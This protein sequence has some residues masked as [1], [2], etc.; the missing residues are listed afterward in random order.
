MKILLIT[1][2]YPP[3]WEAQSIRWYY[4]SKELAKLGF[5]V[6][7]LTIKLPIDRMLD[8]P[9]GINFI[10]ILPGPVENLLLKHK[11]KLNLESEHRANLHKSI[12]YSIGKKVY[13]FFRNL[14]SKLL[15]G[16]VRNEWFPFALNLLKKMDLTKYDILITSHEPM[17]DSLI[18][19]Y[20]KLYLNKNLFWVADIAD[21]LT[22]P[23]YPNI[24]KHILKKLEK[25]I[26]KHANLILVTNENLKHVYLSDYNIEKEK[27]LTLPQ[28]FDWKHYVRRE[29][30]KKRNEEFTLLYA[31]SFYSEFRNPE[32][33]FKALNMFPYKFKLLLAGRIE[34]FIPK[35]ERLKK[36]I[37]YLGILSHL[38]VLKLEK[39]ADVL[40]YLSNKISYQ[41]PGKLFE[42]IGIR[43]PILCIVYNKND[44]AA[45]IVS[46]YNLG[47]VVLN[48][49]NEILKALLEMYEM[50]KEKEE[51]ILPF[52][53]ELYIYSWQYLTC[54]IVQRVKFLRDF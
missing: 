30:V 11:F 41:I 24:W 54:R 23:Y 7:I 50:Y 15:L 19:L 1:Y 17:V 43:K 22:A 27:V 18:G 34:N 33:L 48:D 10:E 26:I 13:K 45:K 40:I 49:E 42:Y 16:E 21:P 4:L 2:S 46:K 36:R 8:L 25:K 51:V 28:G 39:E 9:K 6:D 5:E 37:K 47:K 44:P 29:K 12:L 14:Y 20:I 52:N 31:G 38:K 53:R 32:N 35:N 3:L